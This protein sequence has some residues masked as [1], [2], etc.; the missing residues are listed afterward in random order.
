MRNVEQKIYMWTVYREKVKL[1]HY[2]DTAIAIQRDRVKY[3]SKNGHFVRCVWC[4]VG[5]TIFI[6]HTRCVWRLEI[7]HFPNWLLSLSL[8]LFFDSLSLFSF[9]LSM[10]V[11]SVYTALYLCLSTYFARNVNYHFC[12][13]KHSLCGAFSILKPMEH[14]IH[15]THTY[16]FNFTFSSRLIVRFFFSTCAVHSFGSW[17]TSAFPTNEWM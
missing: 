16:A 8:T 14:H 17:C 1:V 4:F 10:F 7:C 13:E 9:I 3:N 2:R 5:R 6:C 11:Q 12:Y 15:M